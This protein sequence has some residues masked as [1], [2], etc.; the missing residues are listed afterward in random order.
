M[1][2]SGTLECI[3]YVWLTFLNI[4]SHD[5]KR[6]AKIKKK[7]YLYLL[8]YTKCYYNILSFFLELR[9]SLRPDIKPYS[10]P[11]EFNWSENGDPIKD[12]FPSVL[13]GLGFTGQPTDWLH[14]Y[15][16]SDLKFS[17]KLS[18]ICPDFKRIH[19]NQIIRRGKKSWNV[20]YQSVT[21]ISY[22][23]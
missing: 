17:V 14:G 13:I 22:Y 12:S 18:K 6:K 2:Y 19:S 8:N 9:D 4:C 20:I 21:M 23:D 11:V 1:C 5:C 3:K 15:V 10:R 7:L 16:K